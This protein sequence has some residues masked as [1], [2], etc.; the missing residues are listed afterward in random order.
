MMCAADERRN[1]DHTHLFHARRGGD[2]LRQPIVETRDLVRR[3]IRRRN[4]HARLE[5]AVGIEARMH[6]VKLA[7]VL[8]ERD[9]RQEQDERGGDLADDHHISD[10]TVPA[11]ANRT[12]AC[13]P[14]RIARTRARDRAERRDRQER[15]HDRGDCD[16]EHDDR[17]V[18]AH[19]IKA[20]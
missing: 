1:R 17:A 6:V 19:F 11:I 14:K 15:G 5:R 10:A 4:R 13:R 20:W 18:E 7:Q 3:S 12:A 2:P 8:D 9:G 16:H